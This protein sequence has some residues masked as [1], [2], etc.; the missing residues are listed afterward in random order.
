VASEVLSSVADRGRQPALIAAATLAIAIAAA[1]GLVVGYQ[2]NGDSPS[3]PASDSV[4]AGFARDMTVHH[5]Q[6]VEMSMIVR[7]DTDNR[8]VRSIAYDIALTQEQQ[9]GQMSGWLALWGLPQQSTAPAMAWMDGGMSGHDMAGMDSMSGMDESTE[10]SG[11]LMPGMATQ[12]QLAELRTADGKPAE[13]L[14]LQLMIRHHF[15]GIEMA[16][17]AAEHGQTDQVRDLAHNMVIA[18]ETEVDA[19]NDMLVERGAKPIHTL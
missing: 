19:M 2:L 9:I 15:G 1:L 18:Q 13:I 12:S 14:Y 10:E 8:A 6:A 17:Y 7:D 3:Y 11:G 5:S 16:K 4:D